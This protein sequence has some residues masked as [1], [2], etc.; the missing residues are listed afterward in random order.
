MLR[1]VE[2][3]G[4][5]LLFSMF[6]AHILAPLVA[7][8]RRRVRVG[9]RRRPLSDTRATLLLYLALFA[10]GILLFRLAEPAVRHWVTVTAPARVDALFAGGTVEPLEAAIRRAP[11]PEGVNAVLMS[12]ALRVAHSLEHHTRATLDEAIAATRRARWLLVVPAVAFALIT[13]APAFQ[14][15][16]LRILPRGH[17]QWRLEE[18]LRDVNSALAGY[19][20]AQTVAAVIVGFA[21]AIGFAMIGVP[22]AL[23]LGVLAGILELLSAIGPVTVL[24]IATSLGEH[25]AAIL[26]FLIVLRLVQDYLVYPRLVRRGMHLST[27]AV[28]VTVWIGAT[29]AG[30]AGVLLAIPAAGCLSVSVRHLREYRELEQLVARRS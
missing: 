22:Y 20:R 30:A 26:V 12:A 24:L 4:V 5:L 29:L 7:L 18:Y 9:T 21:C 27:P 15:S 17:L 13:M 14:R 8:V 11:L 19:V 1:I 2:G 23:S 3:A 6:F 25:V 28:I 16:A 10:P